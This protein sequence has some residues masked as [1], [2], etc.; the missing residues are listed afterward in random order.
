MGRMP[1][2]A[3][4]RRV[5]SESVGIPEAQPLDAFA[6]GENFCGR[7]L[8]GVHASS[9]DNHFAVGAEAIDE[10]GHG[11]GARGSGEDNLSAAE[12]LEFGCGVG[13]RAIDENVGT[14]FFG[15]RCGFLAAADGSDAIAEFISELNAQWPRPPIPCIATKSPGT[16]P[17]WG[18]ALKV[19]MPAQRSGAASAGS[20]ESGIWARASTGASMYS[21]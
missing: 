4:K 5:S 20:S 13:G 1:V 16:A 17:L 19:V 7:H 12:F 9:D 6:A 11:F 18:K 8:D 21:A 15:E 14:E 3:A 2:I 10:G